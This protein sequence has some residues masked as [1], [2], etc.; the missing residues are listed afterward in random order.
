MSKVKSR[1][2]TICSYGVMILLL[3]SS[4]YFYCKRN[5]LSQELVGL[6]EKLDIRKSQERFVEEHQEDL[7]TIKELKQEILGQQHKWGEYGRQI[8]EMT[9]ILIQNQEKLD[10]LES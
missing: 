10:Q 3:A 1:F 6:Q 2:F 9:K 5:Y 7:N 4:I 8:D